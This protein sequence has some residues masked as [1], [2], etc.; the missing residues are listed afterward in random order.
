MGPPPVRPFWPSTRL[1]AGIGERVL[2][3]IEGRA[4][5]SALGRRGAPVDA[6]IVGVVDRVDVE[7]V[8]AE[9]AR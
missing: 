3:V 8:G 9:F 5:I 2:L 1:R 4:A 7:S 6:A